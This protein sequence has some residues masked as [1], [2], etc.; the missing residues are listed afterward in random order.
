MPNDQR[1]VIRSSWLSV[2]VSSTSPVFVVFL[3]IEIGQRSLGGAIAVVVV[4]LAMTAA[5]RFMQ[6]VEL[7]AQGLEIHTLGMTRVRWQ[8]IGSVEQVSRL[9]SS[10]LTIFDRVK[11]SRRRLPAPRAAFGVGKDEQARARDLIEQ[12]WL[13]YGGTPMTPA[14]R[15]AWPRDASGPD[16]PWAPPREG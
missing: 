12:W 2:F 14:A 4:V 11:N 7:T 9:G 16:D 13:V 5:L 1:V 3:S 10:E 8:Q 6:Y 15:V